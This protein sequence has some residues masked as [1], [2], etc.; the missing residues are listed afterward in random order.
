MHSVPHPRPWLAVWLLAAALTPAVAAPTWPPGFAG[1]TEA[2]APAIAAQALTLDA[3]LRRGLV[4]DATLYPLYRAHDIAPDALGDALARLPEPLVLRRD[5][6]GASTLGASAAFEQRLIDAARQIKLDWL[7]LAQ[8]EHAVAH[9]R[10]AA[11][12][13][14][15]A[16]LL[17]EAQQAAGNLSVLAANATLRDA[18]EAEEALAEAEIALADA[19]DA[20]AARLGLPLGAQ[21][22][23]SGLPALPD[24]PDW[25][26][27]GAIA[28]WAETHDPALRRAEHAAAQAA[29]RSAPVTP[30]PVKLPLLAHP[31]AGADDAGRLSGL[32]DDWLEAADAAQ[33]S[34]RAIAGA[35]RHVEQ[36]WLTAQRMQESRRLAAQRSD[37]ALKHYNGMLLGIYELLDA[38]R[39]AVQAEHD[40][41][42][43]LGRFW[44]AAF[45]LEAALGGELPGAWPVTIAPAS[46][47]ANP[48]PEHAR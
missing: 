8:A 21:P 39:D 27:P 47:S 6:L 37:E 40:A 32:D 4:G 48:H 29:G 42:D 38:K 45:Q 44:G 41:D 3:A 43:A 17:A 2:A 11:E 30:R 18:V 1:R 5:V 14:R 10:A 35:A 13:G 7:A 36:S 34:R 24:R 28:A 9:R 19:Q 16:R 15:A 33:A 26:Q 25:L 46:P 31:L 20:L 12:A 23:T 22:S